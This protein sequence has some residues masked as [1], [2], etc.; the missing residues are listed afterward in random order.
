VC[1]NF[2]GNK[3]DPREDFSHSLVIKLVD[4]ENVKVS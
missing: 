2:V 4:D 3:Q 1:F